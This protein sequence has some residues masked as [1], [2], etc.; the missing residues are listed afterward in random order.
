MNSM[1]LLFLFIILVPVFISTMFI[2]YWTRKTE[3]FGVSIPEEIYHH[4]RLKR[5][6]KQYVWLSGIT[7][8]IITAVSFL[9]STWMDDNTFGIYF[10][11]LI[12][13]YIFIT[14][15]IYLYFHRVMKQL[16]AAENWGKTKPQQM[17]IHTEFRKHKLNHSNLW[18]LLSFIIS[19]ATIA[20]T[21]VLYDR[22]PDRMPMQYNFDGEVTN[23]AEK[24][25][26]SVL[27]MPIMQL[28]LTLLFMFLN[29]MI[30]KA[31]QQI[32]AE[33]PAE[34]M[35]QNIIFRRR[36]SMYLISTGIAIT[37]LFAFIQLTFIFP[38]NSQLITIVPLIFTI[39]ATVGAIIL[40][41]TTGQGG[42]RVKLQTDTNGDVIDRDD[43][44]YWKLG[45]FY[46]NKNDPALFLEKRFGV[47]WTINF[48]RPLAWI[49]FLMIIL[50]AAGI[51]FLLGI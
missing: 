33:K 46:F 41:I 39:G 16:K 32:N 1:M 11:I 2:P 20:M 44:K 24:S 48:A 4:D 19:F 22:I 15:F 38:I 28:Y 40:S 5:M 23:W 10:S 34:S 14:F 37:L 36:W 31:K 26:R 3:S 49:I 29:T 6:R 25:Y 42:S 27:V 7:S 13:L 43:D 12:F 18:F 51:P 30:A 9:L 45:Q 8:L 17:Y 50:L 21:F 47:G 35:Q